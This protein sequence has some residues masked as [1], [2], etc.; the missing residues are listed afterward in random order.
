[1]NAPTDIA[2][3]LKQHEA[4]P[5]L[6]FI[7]CG[8]VDDGKS[9]LIGR[10]LYDS[11]RLF[12]DQLAALEKDS[13][14]HGTQGERIDYALLLDGLA[15]VHKA[16]FLHRD[17][18]PDNIQVRAEDGRLVLLD[19]GSAGQ[20]VALAD[21]DAVVVT[22]G[23]ADP[24]ANVSERLRNFGYSGPMCSHYQATTDRDRF[25]RRF[26]VAMPEASDKVDIWPGTRGIMLRRPR[27]R[28]AGDAADLLEACE[29]LGVEG[30]V[31]KDG[32][33]RYQP[34]ARSR[35][36]RKV[37]CSHWRHQHAPKRRPRAAAS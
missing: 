37:K 9:T 24:A 5:L 28:D 7:T 21:Q 26:G 13:R 33:G 1:M 30:L 12:D 31:L 15:A 23:K 27:A 25:M 14:K 17:I 35:S 6:R 4:K 36:W 16:G 29:T 3:Y 32:A 18:K 8:S 22:P 10:L 20:T 34:G 11:K 2:G 19:F